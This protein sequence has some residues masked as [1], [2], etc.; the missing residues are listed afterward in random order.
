M[1]PNQL[2]SVFSLSILALTS[3]T[4]YADGEKLKP[5]KEVFE[6]TAPR[7]L[8]NFMKVA[9]V[10]WA[11]YG[12]ADI[13]ATPEEA[14]AYKQ[15]NR[16]ALAE[17]IREAAKNGAKMVITPEFGIVGYP[18]IPN[19]PDEDDNF[20]NRK[21]IA[22]FVEKADGPTAKYF[23]ALAK[24]LKVYIHV[25]FAEVDPKTDKYY[26]TAIA[27]D[28]KGK[29]VAKFRKANLYKTEEDFLEH[30][31]KI[32][33]YTSP[34]G[35]VGL[36]IC[37]DVYSSFPMNDYAN[38]KV[39]VLALSTSWAQMN[40]GMSHFVSGAKWVRSYLLAANQRYFPDSGVINPDGKKQS[41][42]RQSVGVAYGYIPLKK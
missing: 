15:E 19:V 5:I 20:R 42:I 14:E 11:P 13:N 27:V 41:H 40:T 4:A 2:L 30:G 38:A 36:I 37:A 18:D 34:V 22:P 21:D 33:T 28:P 32:S 6:P 17:Y 23:S 7:D 25:G 9:V 8:K 12:S 3:V 39:D 16:E 35:K 1:K 29:I 31:T 24:E 26:N 10:Q